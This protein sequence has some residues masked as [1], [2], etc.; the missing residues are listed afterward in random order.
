MNTV[1]K[2]TGAAVCAATLA[3]AAPALPAQDAPDAGSASYGEYVLENGMQVYAAEDFSS[4]AVR[5]E[6][7]VRAGFSAQSP[8]DAGFF[9]LYTRLFRRAA[10]RDGADES[11]GGARPD[12]GKADGAQ[13]D[14]DRRSLA[15]TG[16]ADGGSPQSDGAAPVYGLE[17]QCGADAA[18]YVVTVPPSRVRETLE[19]L[20]RA[21]FRPEFSDAEIVAELSAMRDEITRYADS[22]AGFINSSIDARVFSAA[23]WKQDSGIYPAVFT[24]T[25]PQE[26]RAVLAKIAA[27]WYTPANSALF[28]SGGIEKS[29][30][31][32]IAGQTF[33]QYR[34]G[35]AAR[36]E[37]VTAGGPSRRFVLYD[38]RLSED[39]T[40]IVVQY[41][42]LSMTQAD[43][44][45]AAFSAEDSSLRA[46]LLS[47]A[48][49]NLR[50]GDY[51]NAAAVHRRGSSRLIFQ[52]LL[53]K[54]DCPP[55]EQAAIFTDCVKAAADLASPSEFLRARTAVADA[56][57]SVT[58]SPQTF[59]DYL[60]QLWAVAQPD[61]DGR[62]GR[63]TSLRERLLSHPSR[64]GAEDIPRVAQAFGA[65]EPFVFVIV[66]SRTYARCA[67]GFRQAGYEPVSLRNGSWYTRRLPAG[68]AENPVGKGEY[69]GEAAE[70]TDGGGGIR[71]FLGQNRSALSS[72]SL[73]NGIPVTVM[74]NA[75]TSGAAL[76]VAIQGGSFA[77]G[78]SPG[79]ESVMIRALAAN[80]RSEIGR[81]KKEGLLSGTPA[82]FSE[83]GLSE[84]RVTVECAAADAALCAECMSDALIFGDITPAAADGCVYAVRTRKRVADGNPVSQFYDRAASVLYHSPAYR[85]AFDTEREILERT[86]YRTILAAYTEFLDPALFRITAVGNVRT[87]AMRD[88]L[89]NS[90]GLLPERDG[91]G[92]SGKRA[93][94]KIE[95]PDFPDGRRLTVRLR[96]LFR[97]DT[98]AADAGPMPSVLVPTREF[99]DPVQYWL[100]S[101]P[102]DSDDFLLFNAVVYRLRE[103]ME[104]GAE[105]ICG[106]VTADAATREIQAA[107]FTLTD[108]ESASGADGLYSRAA[109]DLIAA[110]SSDSGEKEAER[111]R[112][113]WLMGALSETATNRG[114]AVLINGGK[115]RPEQ[116]LDDCGRILDARA[117]DF[118][119]AAER[120]VRNA[121]PLRLYS[122]DAK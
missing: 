45:A 4:A 5:I 73:K 104:R 28:I 115:E 55:P 65:E 110:L 101:P 42:S 32:R 103:R 56:F 2:F 34:S 91:G 108:T 43:L 105:K 94:A 47:R 116:Y 17:A 109:E 53:E 83:T 27:G 20:S 51:V 98:R 46:G 24:R 117:D 122:S 90:F 63:I 119:A 23:P 62:A 112:T 69:G 81:R 107:V 29:A 3:A 67:E 113:A 41:T 40:Q 68:A 19:R 25:K 102:P 57:L 100:P 114:T 9:P 84:S 33:G 87:E 106:R 31:L 49:L 92:S 52:A 75:L 8:D 89:E 59:M 79:F 118:R 70:E 1:R 88:A 7:S 12:S 95:A 86:D 111:I 38:E 21:A 10:E 93:A 13:N 64:V 77:D 54:S 35:E 6:Y 14:A 44:A 18:R 72:F 36:T 66:G 74:E 39:F 99:A 96:R 22:P 85:N 76:L 60:S 37:P 30:A 26:A 82:V 50:G 80:I 61:D 78:D 71:R 97:T 11:G 16:K 48:E 15:A 120:Y 58:E 121:A